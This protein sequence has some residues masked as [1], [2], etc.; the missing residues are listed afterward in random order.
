MA[1]V[2]DEARPYRP[3]FPLGAPDRGGSA[4][5]DDYLLTYGRTRVG[6]RRRC[7]RSPRKD[8]ENREP[9]AELMWAHSHHT[10]DA[11]H[12]FHATTGGSFAALV[13]ARARRPETQRQITCIIGAIDTVRTA[14]NGC[15]KL[16]LL[17][18]A[19]A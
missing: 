8:R 17:A 7:R 15:G 6:H 18:V 5:S 1:R 19:A 11:P 14:A 12:R 4:S 9:Q 2:V 13:P 16:Q 3:F 10:V